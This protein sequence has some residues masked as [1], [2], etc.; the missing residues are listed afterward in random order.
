MKSLTIDAVGNGRS[1]ASFAAAE[2]AARALRASAARIDSP[3]RGTC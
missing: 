2:A 3:W 1:A